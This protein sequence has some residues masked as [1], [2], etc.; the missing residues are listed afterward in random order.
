MYT[1]MLVEDD[2]TT[3]MELKVLLQ[4]SGYDVKTA[5]RFDNVEVIVAGEK[6]HL[7][8]MDLNL[9][10][11]Y[12]LDI[13]VKLRA[14]SDVPVIFLTG[15]NTTLDEIRCIDM[16]GDDFI[17]K[18]YNTAVLLGRI[19]NVLHRCYG[20]ENRSNIIEY[21]GI[22]FNTDNDELKYNGSKIELTR[23]E[24]RILKILLENSGTYVSRLRLTEYMWESQMYI[25]DNTLSVN[26]ARIRKKLSDLGIDELIETK[27]G[28]GYRI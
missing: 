17:T 22:E 1:I 4:G 20:S 11:Y 27:R 19:K 6:P 9:S 12:G 26:I 3:R 8:L 15:N 2:E 14:V 25:D 10:G 18:P 7:L 5:E 13:F 28:R 23:T 16:G 24:S 21:K